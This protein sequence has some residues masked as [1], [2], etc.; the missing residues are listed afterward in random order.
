MRFLTSRQF[1]IFITVFSLVAVALMVGTGCKRFFGS[2]YEIAIPQRIGKPIMGQGSASNS[3]MAKL[4]GSGNDKLSY[5]K[6]RQFA[7]IYIEECRAEGVNAD[8]A[9][10]QMCLET[11]F[12]RF[13]GQVE[14][15][16]NNFCGLGATDD[17]AAGAVFPTVRAGVRAHIQHL[18]AY[19]STKPTRYRVIDPRF[20]LVKRGSAPYIKHLAGTWATDP[21]YAS[22]LKRLLARLQKA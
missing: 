9:F 21:D 12:L 20:K 7:Q 1:G 10:V 5:R 15:D 14:A 4:L 13:G 16:Q 3:Q 6:A 17:G 19:A 2:Q 11:N 8:V 22:K 18:K